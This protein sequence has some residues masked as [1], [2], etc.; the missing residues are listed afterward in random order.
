[1]LLREMKV[2]SSRVTRSW[3]WILR[4]EVEVKEDYCRRQGKRLMLI[5]QKK[6]RRQIRRGTGAG[7]MMTRDLTR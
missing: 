5:Q 2:R 3:T 4:I 6:P 7:R 1:M